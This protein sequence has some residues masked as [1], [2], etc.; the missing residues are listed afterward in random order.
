MNDSNINST[1]EHTIIN[2]NPVNEE[3]LKNQQTIF[4]SHTRI[5]SA[6]CNLK[7]Q[8][9][10]AFNELFMIMCGIFIV[11]LVI[12]LCVAFIPRT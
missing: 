1:K 4:R 5:E 2:I 3:M 9:F 11:M 7:L 12:I 8:Q 6:C 10:C